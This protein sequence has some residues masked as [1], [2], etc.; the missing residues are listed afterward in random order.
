MFGH[1]PEDS[2]L[3]IGAGPLGLA[4]A[5]AL[6]EAEI[7]YDH[8]EAT[9][10]VGGNWAHGVYET[11]HIISSKKTTEFPD[12]PMPDH[13][14]DFPS[15]TQMRDYYE[16]FTD[17]HDLRRHIRFDTRVDK[18]AY[19]PDSRWSVGFADGSQAFRRG[20]IVC[21]GHHWSR[22]FPSWAEDYPGELIHS[23]DYQRPQQLAGKRVLVLGGGNS[24]C[25]LVAEAARV[26]ASATWS[27]RRG[28]W[29]LPKTLLGRPVVELVQPWMPVQL[30]RVLIRGLLRVAV[31]RYADYGLPTPDHRLFEA[32][33]SISTEAL[34]YLKHGRIAVRPDVVGVE[35]SEVR[36]ADGRMERFDLVVCATGYDVAFPFLPEGMVPVVGKTA[37]LYGGMLRPEYRHLYVFGTGQVRYGIG[38]LVRP[39]ARL[40]ARWIR[41]Q[42]RIEPNLGEVLMAMGVKPP[43]THLGGP[44]AALRR[45]WLSEHVLEPLMERRARR[46]GRSAAPKAAPRAS[47]PAS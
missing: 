2:L 20:V 4:I 3:L 5:K 13:Y 40:V 7:P 12:W 32:H 33:P 1:P 41:L 8:V 22:R 45:M 26:G 23:K 10:H 19:R 42:D 25:D 36:F 18:V 30:Q 38:P 34:H 29:F 39:G 14:P 17:A 28:Y 21:N 31:G 16:G 35:G 43:E 24:G 6:V 9:D 11:A 46:M 15:R 47:A 44:H 37:Q 27:L